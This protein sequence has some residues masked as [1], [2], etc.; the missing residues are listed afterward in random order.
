[1]IILTMGFIISIAE[2]FFTYPKISPMQHRII[3]KRTPTAFSQ[4]AIKW[5]F[6]SLTIKLNGK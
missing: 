1:M 5:T 4:N 6:W 3:S 2:A